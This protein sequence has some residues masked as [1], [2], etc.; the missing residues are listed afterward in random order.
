MTTEP[1]TH[2]QGTGSGD[3][4]RPARCG[5]PRP[6]GAAAGQL[7]WYTAI[8]IASTLAYLA[9]YQLLR[10]PLGAQPANLL[11]WVLTAVVDT[12]ANRRYTFG[13]AG[14]AGAA[15][16]QLEGLAVFGLG[17]VLTSGSLAALD[18][19]TTGAGRTAELVVLVAANLAAGLLRFLL[20]RGWV[21]A[22]H[23]TIRPRCA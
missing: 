5:A 15:R 1:A 9:L 13:L 17:Y 19:I 8:G 12:A 10:D 4:Q 18:G 7:G 2:L 22:T 16:A 20:L 11:A 23:R 14:R 6:P 21:F 3:P